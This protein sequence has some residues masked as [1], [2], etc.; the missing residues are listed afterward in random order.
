M[1]NDGLGG[2]C[3][4]DFGLVIKSGGCLNYVREIVNGETELDGTGLWLITR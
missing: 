2:V 3:I 1:S 4:A